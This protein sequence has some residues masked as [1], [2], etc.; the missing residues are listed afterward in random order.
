MEEKIEPNSK[1]GDIIGFLENG[2]GKTESDFRQSGLFVDKDRAYFPRKMMKDLIEGG[3]IRVE[4][5]HIV[6]KIYVPTK[7]FLVKDVEYDPMSTNTETIDIEEKQIITPKELFGDSNEITEC[8]NINEIDLKIPDIKEIDDT[9]LINEAR[10]EIVANIVSTESDTHQCLD[11]EDCTCKPLPQNDEET[12]QKN[13]TPVKI[14]ENNTNSVET[15]K[16]KR[17]G[18]FNKNK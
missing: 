8:K 9:D 1:D 16:K 3:L 7:Y 4:K 12:H 6:N 5:R 14:E 18:F 11:C 13:E 17:F 15:P 10:D 2:D